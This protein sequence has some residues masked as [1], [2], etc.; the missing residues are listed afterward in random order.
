MSQV[1]LCERNTFLLTLTTML[2]E[3]REPYLQSYPKT[4]KVVGDSQHNQE[5]IDFGKILSPCCV[6]TL[7]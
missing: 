3:V 7:Y 6:A 5:C 1:N 4:L 2:N